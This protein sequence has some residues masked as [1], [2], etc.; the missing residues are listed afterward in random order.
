MIVGVGGIVGIVALAHVSAMYGVLG[1]QGD[2]DGASVEPA[3]VVV[4]VQVEPQA[5]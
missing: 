3:A 2:E 4:E 1:S 5:G